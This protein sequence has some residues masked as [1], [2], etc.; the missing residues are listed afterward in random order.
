M[1]PYRAEKVASEI[2]SVVGDA[3]LNHLSDPRVSRFASVT[4]V[5]VSADLAIAD[6]YISVMGEPAA[7]R[8]TLAGLQHAR[9]HLQG[10]VARRLRLRQCPEVRFHPDESIKRGT[11]TIRLIEETMGRQRPTDTPAAPESGDDE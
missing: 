9:G 2:R 11:E 8:T 5:S 1:K 4:R 10:L 3:I 6:V 7:Q